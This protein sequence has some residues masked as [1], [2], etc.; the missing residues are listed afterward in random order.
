MRGMFALALW[1]R[2]TRR[3]ILARDRLGKKP[4]YYAATPAAF[5]FGSE[6]K[7]LL[8]WPG[9]PRHPNCGGGVCAAPYFLRQTVHHDS[10][11]SARQI[12][13]ARW[14]IR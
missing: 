10:P 14:S 9:L 5:L 4:L 11:A 8:A 1:D 6:I 2:R 7:A 12:A 13:G 3:L